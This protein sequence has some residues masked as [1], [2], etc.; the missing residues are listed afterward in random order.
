MDECLGSHGCDHVCVN[1][2]GS[3]HCACLAGSVLSNDL[4][5]CTGLI[6]FAVLLIQNGTTS[7]V[8]TEHGTVETELTTVESI[9]T[10]A[11]QTELVKTEITTEGPTT[12]ASTTVAMIQTQRT[13]TEPATEESSTGPSTIAESTTIPVTMIPVTTGG[14]ESTSEPTATLRKNLLGLKRKLAINIYFTTEASTTEQITTEESST[15]PSTIAESTTNPVTMISMTTGGTTEST[16]VE[17][18]CNITCD[19]GGIPDWTE[20][21][22]EC[23]DDGYFYNNS[24]NACE[25]KY[26]L[27][28]N[29]I[30]FSCL[31]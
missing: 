16:T 20:C 2:P 17:S 12:K 10:E 27:N 23:D 14:T 1:T 21:E 6:K 18:M 24:G 30:I 8:T 29:I 3:Y 19:G 26:T 9:T 28:L 25:G 15:G 11:S 5:N 31:I 4:H 13:T 7:P 22:C